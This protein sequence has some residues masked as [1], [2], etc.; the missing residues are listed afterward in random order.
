MLFLE[1]EISNIY[2]IYERKKSNWLP[3]QHT[4]IVSTI[5]LK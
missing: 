5:Y 4:C 3:L 2:N 1:K